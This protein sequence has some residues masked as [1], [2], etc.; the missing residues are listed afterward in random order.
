MDKVEISFVIPVFNE[1]ESLEALHKEICDVCERNE[2]TFEIVFVNDGSTDESW[3]I[4]QRLADSDSRV[5]AL[6]L[7]LIHI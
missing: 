1:E 2:Y 4:M 3:P 5:I 6:K 7:S